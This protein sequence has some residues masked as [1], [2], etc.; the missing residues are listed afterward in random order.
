MNW[1]EPPSLQQ[2]KFSINNL[3]STCEQDCLK[4]TT[5]IKRPQVQKQVLADVLQNRCSQ[6]FRNFTPK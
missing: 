2:M 1:V 3:F 5:Q 6:K 4:I